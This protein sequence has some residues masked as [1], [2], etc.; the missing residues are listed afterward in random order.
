[1]SVF[2]IGIGGIG[3]S[4]VARYLVAQG[5]HVVGVDAVD[6][7]TLDELRA[8]GIV[9]YVGHDKKNIPEDTSLVLISPAMLS[10]SAEDYLEVRRRNIPTMTWQEYV[11]EITKQ[12]DTIAVCG[13]HGKSTTTAMVGL[14]LLAGDLDPTIFVGTKLR[15]FHGSN[16]HMGH[17]KYLVIEA[18]EYHDNFLHYSPKY[19]L[20]VV[21]DVDHLD[22]F[23]TKARYRESFLTFFKKIPSDG[24]LFIHNDEELISLAQEAE[25]PYTIVEDEITIPLSVPGKHV[26]ENGA[27]VASLCEYLGMEENTIE[28]GLQSYHGVWRR[29]EVVGKYQGSPVIDD[30][31]HH[32]TELRATIAA[33]REGYPDKEIVALFQPHQ[34]SRTR[35]LFEGFAQAFGAADKVGIVDIYASRDSEEDRRST[36]A[37]KLAEAIN[38]YSHNAEYVGKLA[39]G[40][41][42]LEK[43]AGGDT[44][45]V[46]FGAGTITNVAREVGNKR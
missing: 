36:S 28:K 41:Q 21:Y 22:Y 33:L 38:A 39:S 46:C 3:I 16:V 1:M 25:V 32:P 29:M 2:C 23:K 4:Y 15:E 9:C 45:L 31:A 5:E 6:S 12:H 19:V 24:M 27:L 13:A 11:G 40:T 8:E 34:Y 43:Q 26:R 42:W 14:A 37:S 7:S 30:Y 35:E 44:V 17:G 10:T 20:C 18:D